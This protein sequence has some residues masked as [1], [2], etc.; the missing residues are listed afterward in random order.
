MDDKKPKPEKEKEKVE[1]KEEEKEKPNLEAEIER[2]NDQLKR[3]V[4]DFQNLEKRTAEERR[5]WIKLANYDLLMQ[6]LPAFDTLFLAEKYIEDDGLK[7][8]VQSLKTTLE[9]VG[10]KRIDTEKKPYDPQTMEVIETIEGQDG[11]VIEEVR[12]G[13]MLYERVLRP[14]GV[15]VGKK[16][17]N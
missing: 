7:F 15:K 6:L 13:F 1:T 12:P 2:L 5:Q 11:M 10:V 9:N 8:T 14:A 3:S 16:Q 4:A 17:S